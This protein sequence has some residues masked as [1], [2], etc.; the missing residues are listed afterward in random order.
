MPRNG[1]RPRGRSGRL[2]EEHFLD[3]CE[4]L[5]HPRPAESDPAGE[6]FT[7]DKPVGKV[8]GGKGFADVWKRGFFAWEYKG[9]HKNLNAAYLQLLEYREALE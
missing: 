6:T 4:L 5:G 2:L 1:R 3:I 9:P 8:S 7:F